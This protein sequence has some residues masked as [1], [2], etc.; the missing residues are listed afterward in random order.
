M[1]K[2]ISYSH[3]METIVGDY[4]FKNI[5]VTKNDYRIKVKQWLVTMVLI[6]T[7]VTNHDFDFKPKTIVG[8]YDFNFLKKFKTIITNYDFDDMV[9]KY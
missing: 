8:D 9:I 3:I 1:L 4:G 2:L 5:I 7:V 6:K